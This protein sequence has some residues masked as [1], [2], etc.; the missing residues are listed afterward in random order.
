MIYDV[1]EKYMSKV[2]NSDSKLGNINLSKIIGI[3]RKSSCKI[4]TWYKRISDA[5]STG[6]VRSATPTCSSPYDSSH[7]TK[8]E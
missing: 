4:I 2:I 3:T 5:I 7:S 6:Y 8:H 1:C